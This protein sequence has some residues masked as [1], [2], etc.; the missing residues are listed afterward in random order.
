[1]SENKISLMGLHKAMGAE[2][3]Q[4]W[5]WYMPANY[6]NIETE[7]QERGSAVSSGNAD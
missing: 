5:G 7:V 3:E 2:F 4:V 1:M 6:E